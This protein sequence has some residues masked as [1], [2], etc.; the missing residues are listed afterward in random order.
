MNHKVREKIEGALRKNLYK[1]EKSVGVFEQQSH[2][3][4]EWVIR[5]NKPFAVFAIF[6][7]LRE[8]FKHKD[9][10]VEHKDHKGICT[11]R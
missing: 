10:D 2:E 8:K 11:I 1:S 3:K 7:S 4:G 5:K 6:V 9:H